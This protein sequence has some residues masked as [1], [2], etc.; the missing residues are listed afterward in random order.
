M[1]ADDGMCIFNVDNASL[2]SLDVLGDDGFQKYRA[3]GDGCVSTALV[4]NGDN[5]GEDFI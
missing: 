4:L 5:D 3:N 2:E 1:S